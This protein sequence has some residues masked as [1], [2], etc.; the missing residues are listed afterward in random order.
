MDGE[1]MDHIERN[2]KILEEKMIEK[3]NSA[4]EF[5]KD[6]ID[7]ELDAGIFNFV[8]KPVVKSFYDYW[9]KGDARE[10]T[11][12]QIKVTLD[13]GKRLVR[14]G[15]Y[16]NIEDAVEDNFKEYLEGDQTFRQCKKTHENFNKLKKN[17]KECFR[18]Q[19]ESTVK[20]LNVKEDVKNYDD[21]T[22]AAFKT[23]KEAYEAL[24]KQLE[25]NDKGIKI[26]EKD[27]SILKVPTG[28]SIILKVLRKGFEETKH[29]L[30]RALNETYN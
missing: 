8:V 17:T 1:T 28:K 30:R 23:K 27:P 3:M 18:S 29:D 6:L 4:L 5:G 7:S 24:S 26:V 13:C 14:N 2:Y 10:G 22:R 9:A 11:L 25:F 21:L 15:S 16:E 20:F 19:V 12:Q